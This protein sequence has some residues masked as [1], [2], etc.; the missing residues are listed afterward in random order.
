[1]NNRPDFMAITSTGGYIGRIFW[2]NSG[3]H[4][5]FPQWGSIRLI[6][7]SILSVTFG[8]WAGTFPVIRQI[9]NWR[10]YEND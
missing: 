4:P 8:V 2:T 1:M 10:F 9:I 3:V 6:P 7:T 5:D